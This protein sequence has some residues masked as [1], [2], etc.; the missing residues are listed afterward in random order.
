MNLDEKSL[1]E[2]VWYAERGIALPAFDRQKMK[3]Q[4]RK[5]PGWLHFGPGN[6]FRAFIAVL[7]QRLLETGKSGFGIAVAT[8]N[9][10][11]MIEKIY[12][13]HDDLSL[14]VTM[15]PDRRMTKT[16]VGSLSESL[17]GNPADSEDWQRLGEIAKSPSLQIIS[18]TITE[19][20]YKISNLAQ[21]ADPARPCSLMGKAAALLLGRYRNGAVPVTLLSLDNC[22]HNGDVLKE[23]VLSVA[24]L[25][26]ENGAA[27]EGFLRYVEKDV[28][29]P[30]T[31]ID[32]IT[33]RPSE[34]VR[35][36][37]AED[38]FSDMD[39]VISRRGGQ[40][41]PFVNAEACEYLVVEDRFANG[42]P[43]LEEAGVIFTDRDT[44][45]K[46]ERMKV[47]T[48]L[49]P[50]H[51]ALAVFGCLLGFQ[52]IAAEM[53][54]PVLRALAERIG[55]EGMRVVTDPKV[56]SPREFLQQCLEER[57]PNPAIPDTPQRIACDTSQKVGIRFGE[58]IRAYAESKDL[59][60]AD[61]TAI[62][63]VAAGWCRYLMGIDDEGK[64][65]EV[66][67][68]P[69]LE[70]LQKS[71]AG[72]GLGE[73]RDVHGLL[74]GILSDRSIWGSDLYASGLGQK[75]EAYFERMASGVHGVRE[76]LASS[77]EMK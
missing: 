4:S 7:Q 36:M 52:S 28:A 54:D 61:L 5:Q 38:G 18:F 58:T 74:S 71:F 21:D 62:P 47:C 48:C 64:T 50:L 30:W 49:N 12:R 40:Y 56:L 16:V 73:I 19:K 11:E 20:G 39:F 25:W 68:D 66:S 63:L 10:G 53:Q 60:A 27:D 45:E 70:T 6:I 15:H 46:V 13:P 59:S 44:V 14:L 26:Q 31:M 67:P 77:L 35:D 43:P 55:E 24:R 8:P 41:A 29:F 72:K 1:L 69:L 34:A 37:L 23:A 65:F 51:T 3:E 22:S 9:T 76:T 17:S 57:F 2:A 42:R 75:A 33:P 32:K